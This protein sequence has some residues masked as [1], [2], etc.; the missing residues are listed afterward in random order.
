MTWL[1]NTILY[2]PFLNLLVFLYN[3]VAFHDFGVSIVLTTLVIRLILSPLSI[4]AFRSQKILNELQPE[5]KQA[6]EKFKNDPQ[7]QTK[8][9]MGLYRRY[10]INPFSGCLPLLIQ[11]PVL[12]ALY[13][14][15]ISGFEDGALSVLYDFIKNPGPLNQTSLGFID[16][17]KRS[18]PLSVIAGASQFFQTKLSMS[19]QK[20]S[21][22]QKDQKSNPLIMMNQQ[23]LYFLPLITII[24]SLSFPAGLPLYW[25]ATTLFS[26]GE[27]LYINKFQ[28]KNNGY[29]SGKSGIQNS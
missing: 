15:S 4:K 26:I 8:E 16:L 20:S 1:F 18:F 3:T 10:N 22:L 11:L 21:V 28:F 9:I 7:R 25:I 24:V 23:M 5:V 6:Q 29:S 12:I 13:R 27:Q 14:I 2:A 17:T 19:S